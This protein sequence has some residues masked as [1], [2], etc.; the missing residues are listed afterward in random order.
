MEDHVGYEVANTLGE[1]FKRSARANLYRSLT[2]S[3]GEAV[4]EITYPV[5][6][7]LA[8]TGPCSAATLALTVG[9]DR[10]GISRRASRLEKDGLLQ[11]VP[12][13]EDRRSVLLELTEHGCEVVGVL[14]QRLA[15]RISATLDTWPA[16][17]ARSFARSLRRFAEEGPFGD[18][19][20]SDDARE[21]PD[22]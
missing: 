13:P 1:L 15:A 8:R 3:L 4:D 19:D 18:V 5:L 2:E 14:R 22:R 7:G 17:E 10:S 6:S 11:R 16:D 9:L 21:T 12:D 20:G